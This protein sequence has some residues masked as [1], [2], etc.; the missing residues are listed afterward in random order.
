MWDSAR[1]L[2]EC[3]VLDGREG[4][5]L[6]EERIVLVV[7]DD[8]QSALAEAKRV[9]EAGRESYE[10]YLGNTVKWQFSGV[11]EVYE[12]MED[13]LVSGAEVYSRLWVKK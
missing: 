12:I 3:L 2:Y 13:E 9:G 5:A 7:A 8:E 4:D 1:I 11:L 10:D 6:I